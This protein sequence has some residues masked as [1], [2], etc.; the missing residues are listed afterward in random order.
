MEA[1]LLLRAAMLLAYLTLTQL[2]KT[3]LMKRFG[4][5]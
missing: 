2:T 1:F 5:S 4:L 3:W